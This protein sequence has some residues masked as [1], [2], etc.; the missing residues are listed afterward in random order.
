MLSLFVGHRRPQ[1]SNE[2]YSNDDDEGGLLH[3]YQLPELLILP[4]PIPEAPS[5]KKRFPRRSDLAESSGH[6]SRRGG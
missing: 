5:N 3:A 1:G 2:D 6:S 4:P